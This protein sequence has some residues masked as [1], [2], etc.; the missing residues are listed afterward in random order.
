MNEIPNRTNMVGQLFGERQRFA[1]QTTNPLAQ[2][3][4]QAL[5]MIRLTTLLAD[6]SMSFGRQDRSVS[7]PEIAVADRTLSIDWREALPECLRSDVVARSDRNSDYLSRLSI[8][9]QP[10]PLLIALTEDE[11]PQLIAL[12]NHSPLFFGVTSTLRGTLA[13]LALT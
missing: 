9:R 12:E 3:V 8:E 4:V 13:Y 10:K 2:R 6:R 11:R 1:H 5:D 7:V